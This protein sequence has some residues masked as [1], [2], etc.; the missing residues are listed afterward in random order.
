MPRSSKGAPSRLP[1]SCV[2][3][4]GGATPEIRQNYSGGQERGR[5]RGM[6]PDSLLPS[7]RYL[8]AIHA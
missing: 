7:V 5:E 6:P 3:C 1:G 4:S 8:N 2:I